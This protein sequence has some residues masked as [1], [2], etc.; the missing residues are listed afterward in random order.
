MRSIAGLFGRSPFKLLEK[1]MEQV[2]EAVGEVPPI[3]EALYAGDHDKVK[4]ISEKILKHEH[5][6]DTMKDDIRRQIPNSLFM[7]VDRRDFLGLLSAQDD[8]ADSVEDLS[9][10]LRLKL[11]DVPEG[12]KSQLSELVEKVMS[13]TDMAYSIVQELDN[14]M[15]VSFGGPEADMVEKMI[16][17]LGTMEWEADKLQFKTTKQIFLMEEDLKKGEFFILLEIVRKLGSIADKSEKVGKILRMFI[18]S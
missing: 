17:D 15:E 6:A 7:P 18:T 1:H 3:F 10:V 9:I 2:K 5:K 4:L 12:M 13:I 8:I 14:L 11:I 16:T